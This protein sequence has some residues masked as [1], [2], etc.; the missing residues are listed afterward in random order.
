MALRSLLLSLLGPELNT[1]PQRTRA[2]K[3][4]F[5]RGV[6]KGEGEEIEMMME[7]EKE[8]KGRLHRRTS[9]DVAT[10]DANQGRQQACRRS[11]YS[12]WAHQACQP[13]FGSTSHSGTCWVTRS[14]LVEYFRKTDKGRSHMRT[15]EWSSLLWVVCS[16]SSNSDRQAERARACAKQDVPFR[17]QN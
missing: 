11:K 17:K 6:W 7:K 4:C 8:K 14:R 5:G 12:P 16:A 13:V 10:R 2:G 3:G 9:W 15:C 1:N